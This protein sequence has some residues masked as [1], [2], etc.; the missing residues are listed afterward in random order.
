L[1]AALDRHARQVA[2]RRPTLTDLLPLG[3]LHAESVLLMRYLLGELADH[4]EL[5]ALIEK[6][7]C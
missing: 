1:T 3:D 7:G 5:N 2:E 4:R 6:E